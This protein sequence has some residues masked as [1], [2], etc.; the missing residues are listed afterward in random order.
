[1]GFL[2]EIDATSGPS[3]GTMRAMTSVRAGFVFGVLALVSSGC[4]D[5]KATI[6]AEE[7]PVI[8]PTLETVERA[9]V[10]SGAETTVTFTKQ[11]PK[12]GMVEGSKRAQRTLM[13]GSLAVEK[14]TV[15]LDADKSSDVEKTEECLEVKDK[16][17][18]KLRVTYAKDRSKDTTNGQGKETTNPNEGHAYIVERNGK[19]PKIKRED[20]STTTPAEIESIENAYDEEPRTKKF[21]DALPDTVKVGDSLDAFAKLIGEE[22]S[23]EENITNKKIDSS[24]VVQSIGTVDGK[25]VVTLKLNVKLEGDDENVGHLSV[26]MTGTIDL[27]VDG[28]LPVRSNLS[29][30]VSVTLPENAG[31]LKGTITETKTSTYRF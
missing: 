17:C 2:P 1:M 21:L 4:E 24:V 23:S 18:V 10:F 13:K 19:T 27:L 15:A 29:G 7:R 22:A 14:R 3:R 12:V 9:P 5:P 30:P 8:L 28:A 25:K 11:Y 6:V 16:N 20:G 31:V 26:Q